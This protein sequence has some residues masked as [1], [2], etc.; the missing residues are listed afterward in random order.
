VK[1][2]GILVEVET[3]GGKRKLDPTIVNPAHL[4]PQLRE[5]VCWQCHLEGDVR[6]QR[7]D[8]S[9]YD[10]RPGLPLEAFVAVF[11]DAADA[12]YDQ[13]VNHVEQMVQSR[14]Y[15][16]SAGPKQMGCVSCHDPHEKPAPAKQVGFYRAACLTCHQDKPCSQPLPQRLAHNKGDSCIACHMAPFAT[17]NVEHVSSTDHR[18]PR[19][20]IP[21]KADG[22]PGM[23]MGPIKELVSV[24]EQH[25][26]KNDPEVNR[27]KAL[28]SGVLARIGRPMIVPLNRE[29]EEAL[30]RDP[31]DVAV[32]VQYA[33][34]LIDRKEASSALPLF[35]DI[36]AR[37]PNH[38]DAQFGFALACWELGRIDQEAGRNDQAASRIEQAAKSWRRLIE[39]TP[40]QRGYRAGLISMLIEQRRLQEAAVVAQAWI[41]FDPGMPDARFLMRNILGGLG[42]ITEAQE[43]DRSG[44]KLMGNQKQ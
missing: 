2:P 30:K 10:Y 35:E 8:R 29:F 15:K 44:R 38:E 25:N 31:N 16:N 6:V 17:S 37:Q 21:R 9:R 5:S 12:S 33:L 14:C 42:K 24:F 22:P 32:K 41:E 43:Q 20:P 1:N 39:R 36:L 40:S 7:R 26:V 13:I 3:A 23:R 27:D 19:K 28:A 34:R 18:I 4:S 11:D